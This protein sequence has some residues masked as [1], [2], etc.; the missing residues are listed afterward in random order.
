MCVGE[1]GVSDSEPYI[2]QG[3]RVLKITIY[4]KLYT[5]KE[6]KGKIM[7]PELSSNIGGCTL[8][9]ETHSTGWEQASH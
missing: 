6:L 5:L 4:L 2:I 1:V 8:R 3:S 7:K 9:G